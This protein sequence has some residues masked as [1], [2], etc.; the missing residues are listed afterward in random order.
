[1]AI[2][3]LKLYF[4]IA[5]QQ[6]FEGILLIFW[7]IFGLWYIRGG[8]EDY[9]WN[10]KCKEQQIVKNDDFGRFDTAVPGLKKTPYQN[11]CITVR[12]QRFKQS[13][14]MD[15]VNLSSK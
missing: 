15:R 5:D 4:F 7:S 6:L 11:T 1:M 12:K 8:K 9:F 13:I 3:D 10:G 14:D 2:K